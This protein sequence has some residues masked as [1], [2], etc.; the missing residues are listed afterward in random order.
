MKFWEKLSDKLK[1]KGFSAQQIKKLEELFGN[2]DA[3]TLLNMPHDQLLPAMSGRTVAEKRKQ[4][5]SL[6]ATVREIIQQR[7]AGEEEQGRQTSLN[8]THMGGLNAYAAFTINGTAISGD[9]T[10]TSIG[11]VD[12]SS[13]HIELYSVEWGARIEAQ[14]SASSRKMLPIRIHKRIDQTTPDFY[15]ALAKNA[16]LAG[17][18]KIFDTNPEDGT[19]RHRFRISISGARVISIESQC[20]DVLGTSNLK[21]PS[22]EVIEIIPHVITYTDVVHSNEYTDEWVG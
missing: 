4:I 6:L 15:R 19:I 7:D 16:T 1:Q 21:R 12:V 2:L 5:E 8:S 18:I 22:C 11:G 13:G 17:D 3:A 14:R 10:M 9:T 20:P